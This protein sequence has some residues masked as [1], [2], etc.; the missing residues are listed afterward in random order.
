MLNAGRGV[1]AKPPRNVGRRG[2]HADRH[3][4]RALADLSLARRCGGRRW[5]PRRSSPTA[6]SARPMPRSTEALTDQTCALVE[7]LQEPR[8]RRDRDDRCARRRRDHLQQHEHDVH[9]VREARGHADRRVA[10]RDPPPEQGAGRRHRRRLTSRQTRKGALER[11]S[12]LRRI[13]FW[14]TKPA[15]RHQIIGWCSFEDRGQ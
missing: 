13:T 8:P 1:V 3:L 12:C 2:R 10:R 9:R 11:C 5:R 7:R 15:G 6:R 14:K 4:Y